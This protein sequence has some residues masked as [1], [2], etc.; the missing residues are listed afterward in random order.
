[1]SLRIVFSLLVAALGTTAVA[2]PLVIENVTLVSA[3]LEMPQSNV[4]VWIEDGRIV[5]ISQQAFENTSKAQVLDGSNRYLTPGLMDNHVHVGSIPGIGFIGSSRANDHAE[6]VDAYFAQQPRSF[7]YYGVT[8]VMNLG[9]PAGQ[10]HFTAGDVH[11]DFFSCE[12]I[13]VVGGYPHLD[14]HFTLSQSRNFI[15]EPDMAYPLPEHVDA[16]Q[17]TP[18]A[19][20]QRIAATGAPCIKVYVENG[21][22]EAS[23]WPLMQDST[24]QRLGRAA[25]AQ[26]I[27]VIAHANAIDMYQIALRH[28]V[29]VMSHGM[30]NWQWPE[31]QGK[32]PVTE[33]LDKVI[34]SNTGV[35][36]TIQVMQALTGMYN[37]DFLADPARQAVLPAALL[38]WFETPQGQWFKA[39]VT[40]D[41]GPD[42]TDARAGKLLGYGL[43]R[44]KQATAYLA[45]AGHPLLL[46]SDYPSSPSYAAAPGLATYQELLLMADAGV[47]NAALFAAATINGARQFSM[48]DDY[49]TVEAGKVANLLLLDASP[50][51]SVTAWQSIHKIILH[52]R[53]I[54]R[55]TL[56][57]AQ[58]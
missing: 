15:I 12:P 4:H 27:P 9:S 10:E 47:D 29:D 49:G 46:A 55:A 36:P 48:L 34:A 1:M 7:L 3:H 56:A 32:A 57:V 24:M 39:E 18:E 58:P 41:F 14:A 54:D 37:D 44:A 52:G 42:M 31:Q 16:Q 40:A 33:T 21:F 45:Q 11:P 19:V 28:Q 6:L 25:K 26:G 5:Q 2:Q 35:M 8:Q 50:L 53:V 17:H 30:W 13:P 38:A 22:G 23:H 51:E 20:V 43:N